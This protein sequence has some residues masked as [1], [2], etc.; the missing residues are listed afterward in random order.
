MSKQDRQ[1]A[2]TIS[3]LERKYEFEAISGHGENSFSGLARQ[4]N[5]L[6]QTLAQFMATTNGNITELERNAAVWFYSGIPTLENQ[7]FVSWETAKV[8]EKHIGDF[9]YDTDNGSMYL[10]KAT[11][12]ESTEEP[13][14]VYEWV[15]IIKK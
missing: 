1:G 4:I 12:D 11:T 8:K 7:P 2:R 9:Y 6:N 15:N 5:S 14:L 3:D 13:T 10:L